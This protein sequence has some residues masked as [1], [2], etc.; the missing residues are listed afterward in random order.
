[1]SHSFPVGEMY[2]Q[3]SVPQRCAL[4]SYDEKCWRTLK[5][6]SPSSGASLRM[7]ALLRAAPQRK[8]GNALSIRSPRM[9]GTLVPVLTLMAKWGK[10]HKKT[11]EAESLRAAS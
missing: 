9:G 8:D 5:K 2:K 10:S 6:C 3:E 4:A 11:K 7:T 1:M